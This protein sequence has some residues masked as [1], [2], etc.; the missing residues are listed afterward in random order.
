VAS[1]LVIGTC[2]VGSRGTRVVAVR[3]GASRKPDV[4]Y[5][6]TKDAPYV[7]VPLAK[8]ELLFLWSDRGTVTC[9][10]AATG[11]QVWQERLGAN[12]FGSPVCVSDRLY[13]ISKKGQVYVLAAAA[14][15]K[16]LAVNPLGEGSFATPAVAGGRMY[17]RT[18]SHL[19]SIG[20]R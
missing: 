2:G 14:E 18:F 13:C 7:P 10:R 3:P 8:G 17:L 9:L 16:R 1:G 19:I 20:G 5:S 6:V 11:E 4:V 12:F 15:Y